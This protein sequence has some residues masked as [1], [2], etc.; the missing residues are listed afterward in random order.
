MNFGY[1]LNEYQN[2]IEQY[3]IEEFDII[4]FYNSLNRKV[5]PDDMKLFFS[6]KKKLNKVKTLAANKANNQNVNQNYEIEEDE[7]EDL[8]GRNNISNKA[9]IAYV[10][11]AITEGG[12]VEHDD[13]FYY[14]NVSLKFKK[15][16]KGNAKS[17]GYRLVNN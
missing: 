5:P 9:K 8:F 14:P 17:F 10:D 3:K 1:S 2:M 15:V 12:F 13:T 16:N 6:K 11:A 4:N 7:E